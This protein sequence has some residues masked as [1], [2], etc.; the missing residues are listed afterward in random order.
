MPPDARHGLTGQHR[1]LAADMLALCSD[2]GD[3]PHA[4]NLLNKLR[5]TRRR[6]GPPAGGPRHR[7]LGAGALLGS[8]AGAG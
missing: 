5:N 1:R 4:L 3:V 8:L 6:T 2:P 7:T